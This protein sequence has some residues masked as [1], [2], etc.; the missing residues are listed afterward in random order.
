L[1]FRPAASAGCANCSWRAIVQ[2]DS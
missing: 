2:V 1:R